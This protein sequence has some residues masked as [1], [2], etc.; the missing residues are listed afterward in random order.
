MKP[1]RL[2]TFLLL[3]FLPADGLYAIRI[4]ARKTSGSYDIRYYL[5]ED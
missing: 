3:L 1:T 5:T 2:L 4:W